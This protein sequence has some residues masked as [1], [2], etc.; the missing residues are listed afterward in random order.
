M[1]YQIK[2]A[3]YSESILAPLL[4][5]YSTHFENDSRLLSSKY[6]EWLYLKNPF[7][8]AKIVN[9]S[10][11]G[12]LAGS[13]A[14]IPV[15]L[16]RK[17]EKMRAYYVVNVLVDPAMRGKNLFSRMI[18]ASV[19]LA[20]TENV[21]L[22]GHPNRAA[23]P[24]WK[25]KKMHFF[26]S[27]R[28]CLLLRT[29]S[30]SVKTIKTLP[31][32]IQAKGEFFKSI[33]NAFDTWKVDANSA[34]VDWRYIGHPFTKYEIWSLEFNDGEIA[35]QF[36]KKIKPGIQLLIDQYVSPKNC[37]LALRSVKKLTVG[38]FPPYFEAKKISFIPLPIK[39]RIPLFLT[40]YSETVP[41]ESL[42]NFGLSASDF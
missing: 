42:G 3:P 15:N 28:P 10:V 39:K 41:E 29:P 20:H 11:G 17:T 14:L 26:G 24:F 19:E 22:I 4:K 13:M 23:Y 40:R 25:R 34:Y 38:F 2:I 21:S 12:V 32:E 30:W 6:L 33:P 7:G 8:I 35:I 1:E 18:T 37:H 36:F 5:L 16:R 31:D 9:I 27:L